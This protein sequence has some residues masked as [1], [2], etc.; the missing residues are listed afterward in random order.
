M[1]VCVC[2]CVCVH[3]CTCLCS[4]TCAWLCICGTVWWRMCGGHT[5]THVYYSVPLHMDKT[6]NSFACL[7]T[8][9]HKIYTVSRQ[10]VWNVC[11]WNVH[12]WGRSW[13]F[14]ID[15]REHQAMTPLWSIWHHYGVI[16]CH[17]G[18][19]WCHYGVIWCY[20]GVKLTFQVCQ[21]LTLH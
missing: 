11:V 19:I 2:V 14:V 15:W 6:L 18:V 16:W 13:C 21:P 3:V 10:Q 17:Y 1:C 12:H 5:H 4:N 20:Y 8:W 9:Q 7:M